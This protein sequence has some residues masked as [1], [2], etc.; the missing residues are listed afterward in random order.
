MG[1]MTE[2]A[3]PSR[4]RHRMLGVICV[5][6]FFA[7]IARLWFLQV[8]DPRDFQVSSAGFHTRSLHE[9]G[10]RGRILDRNGKVL[11][12]NR[13][14]RVV[15]LEHDPI[16]QLSAADRDT[17]FSK[18]ADVLLS[19]DYRIK[20]AFIQRRFDDKR[21]A[22]TEPV[23]IAREVTDD[24]SIYL[25]EHH[26]E[27]PGV[28]V[29]QRSVR[30]YPYGK[31]AAHLLG[32]VGQIG[33]KAL[34]DQDAIQGTP[35]KPSGANAKPYQ[36]GDEIGQDGAERSFE[37]DLRA[38]PGDKTI[39]V[40]AR[41][42]YIR[43]IDETKPR[44]GDDVWLTID[45]N[46][47]AFA[48]QLLDQ[49]LNELRGRVVTDSATKKQ[50]VLKAPQG[51]V[52]LED[53]GSGQVLAMASAP[54]YDPSTLVDGIDSDTWTYL[55]DPAN[56]QPLFNWALKGQYAPGSTFKLVTAHAAIENGFLHPSN[57]SYTDRGTY[58]A[59][60]CTGAACTKRN[61]GGSRYGTIGLSKAITVSS[62]VFF[63]WIGDG[64]WQGRNAYGDDALQR[65]AG[66][67]GLGERSGI[68][69]PGES[70][71]RIPTPEL[72]KANHE[73]H[74]DAFPRG[75]WTVGDEMNTAVGQGE[76]LVTPLQL[77]NT[78]AT[79]ANGGTLRTPQILARVTR[80]RDLGVDPAN[81]ANF[82]ILR[83]G[84]PQ[85]VGTV[86]FTADHYQQIYEGLYGVINNGGTAAGAWKD[87]P[88]A[89]K[90][91]GKTGTAQVAGKADTSLFV[92]FGPAGAPGTPANYAISAVIPEAGFGT[93]AAAPLVFSIMRAI[94][95]GQVPPAT[96]V[97]PLPPWVDREAV[98]TTTTVDPSQT[99]TTVITDT[100]A[101]AG[102]DT[103][104]TTPDQPLATDPTTTLSTSR[105]TP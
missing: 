25:A 88:A 24:L 27:F 76:V 73:A 40:D 71:G 94:S 96:I 95:L 64:L 30:I 81:L 99:P 22:P 34:A 11:V 20:S 14:I 7:L 12:D 42:N 2:R 50:Y 28:E 31:V 58:T 92:A 49:K 67:Y 59:S 82:D 52:V 48:E 32:Y 103:T 56:G 60:N 46:V 65:S 104:P 23:P 19:F 15:E 44:A 85:T 33:E 78:Y 1:A 98:S 105:G 89:W 6:L 61:S 38:V 47:Q 63:Y 86:P 45:I 21:F 72:L 102:G 55:Q 57:D 13:I 17:M 54:S 87:S 35:G 70:T 75:E 10:T 80:A 36:T 79:F 77:A 91:A 100:S 16:N 5:S 51:S 18:L 3:D 39:Q 84:Q 83:E 29:R 74:P 37:Q 8:I 62:D 101:P 43:T 26:D 93:D 53:P 90:M 97:T 9:Q 41:G 69:L 66:L 68:E 4:A